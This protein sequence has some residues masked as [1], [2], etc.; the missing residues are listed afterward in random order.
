MDLT[1]LRFPVL[2][3]IVMAALLDIA[4][5]ANNYSHDIAT[6]LLAVSGLSLW[7]IT[8]NYPDSGKKTDK[9]VDLCYLSAN[10]AVT[11]L[12]KYSLAWVLLA[13]VPRVI[14]YKSYEWSSAAGELQVAAILFKHVMMFTLVGLGLYFWFR[15]RGRL[16]ELRLK[17]NETR[18]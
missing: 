10:K 2:K 15:I 16:R 11:K 4:I 14:F 8:K 17:H 5:M 18:G 3:F 7:I 6:A 9:G 12:A 1:C 13:G